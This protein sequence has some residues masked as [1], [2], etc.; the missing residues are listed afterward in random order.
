M[1]SKDPESPKL[2]LLEQ[3]LVR[4]E[5]E[6]LVAEA[7]LSNVTRVKLKSAFTQ[8]F[9]AIRE[10]GEKMSLIASYG[11][12]L[13]D[14]VDA[15]PVTPGQT[16]PEYDG[17]LAS[18]AI[19]TECED[20]LSKWTAS[21]SPLTAE[22]SPAAEA[23]SLQ[24]RSQHQAEG[25]V[26]EE[27]AFPDNYYRDGEEWSDPEHAG[28]EGEFGDLE[29]GDSDDGGDDAG[30]AGDGEHFDGHDN[31]RR[32]SLHDADEHQIADDDDF[33]D[34]EEQIR[35]TEHNPRHQR[36]VSPT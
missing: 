4:V 34:H 1:R 5:A 36:L 21:A 33:H 32:H 24:T 16:R 23:L 28:L 13:L 9:D 25:D 30:G 17:H 10:H 18:S 3:Q 6:S 31:A 19:M 20:A 27:L 22:L 35:E 8:K 12:H 2:E 14:L 7:Q 29:L 26:D 11:K 15:N